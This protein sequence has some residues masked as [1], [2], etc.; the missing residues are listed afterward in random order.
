MK[1]EVLSCYWNCLIHSVAAV[2]V[3]RTR[4][5]QIAAVDPSVTCSSSSWRE[6]C[7]VSIDRGS[8]LCVNGTMKT[9]GND[10]D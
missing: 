7:V 8:A 4:T 1:L 2:A 6:V 9:T 10:D 5:I 3:A